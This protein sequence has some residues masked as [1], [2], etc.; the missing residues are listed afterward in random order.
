MEHELRPACQHVQVAAKAAPVAAKRVRTRARVVRHVSVGHV[1]G[2]G[3]AVS[4]A[5]PGA[6]PFAL[7]RRGRL[8]RGSSEA[9]G[10]SGV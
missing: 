4:A 6:G 7:H 9:V 2:G 1:R 10:Y 3:G 8:V 5:A